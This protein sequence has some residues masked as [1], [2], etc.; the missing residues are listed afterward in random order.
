MKYTWIIHELCIKQT[1]NKLIKLFVLITAYLYLRFNDYF[2][3]KKIM[4]YINNNK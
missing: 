4:E 2:C 1:N 3:K